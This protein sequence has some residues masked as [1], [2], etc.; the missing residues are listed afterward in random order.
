[1]PM[2]VNLDVSTLYHAGAFGIPASE[3]DY[4]SPVGNT[5][6]FPAKVKV[7]KWGATP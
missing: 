1:M 7:D 3:R 2:S 4:V 6:M 5:P